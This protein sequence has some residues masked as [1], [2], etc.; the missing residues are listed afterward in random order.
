MIAGQT[1]LHLFTAFWGMAMRTESM[2][3]A[4]PGSN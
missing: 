3:K 1:S 2:P 4:E